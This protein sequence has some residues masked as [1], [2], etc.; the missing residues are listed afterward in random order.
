MKSIIIK[1]LFLILTLIILIYNPFTVRIMA[2]LIAHEYQLNTHYFYNL[3][4]QESTFRTL[5][6]SRQRALGPGQVREGTAR[7][8]D[9]KYHKG[10]L[11][12]PYY[13]L[14]I[15]AQYLKYLL[16]KYNHNWSLAIAAYN[17]GETNV[18]KKVS[19][20]NI[21]PQANY[22]ILFENVRETNNLLYHVLGN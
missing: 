15:S 7:Y 5:A 21:Q 1:L 17:W 11:Y 4:K 10:M 6:I 18:D 22:R 20:I 9:T 14:K 8:L 13:N 3:I 12:F 2:I 16:N 19:R